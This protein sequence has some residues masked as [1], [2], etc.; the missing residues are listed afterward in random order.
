MAPGHRFDEIVK[1][2][3][4]NVADWLPR[5]AIALVAALTL[6]VVYYRSQAPGIRSAAA[7]EHAQLARNIADG[8][9][10]TTRCVRPV[11]T[12]YLRKNGKPA[13][14]I[15]SFPDLR[16]APLYPL[17]LATGLRTWRPPAKMESSILHSRLRVFAPEQRVLIPTTILFAL[18]TALLVFLMAI[19]LADLRTGLIAA[20]AYFVSDSVLADALSGTAATATTFFAT[21]ALYLSLRHAPERSAFRSVPLMAAAVACALTFLTRYAAVA[22]VPAALLILLLRVE[23]NRW[24]TAA[25]VLVLAAAV[26]APWIL[27]NIRVTGGPFGM[28]SYAVLEDSPD[29]PGDS[30]S[31]DATPQPNNVKIARAV[32]TKAVSQFGRLFDNDLRT[33]GSGLIVCFFLVSLF[34]GAGNRDPHALKWATISGI[35]CLLFV[36]AITDGNATGVLGIFLPAITVCAT[37]FFLELIGKPETIDLEWQ[38]PLAW[39]FVALAA[40]PA[41]CTIAGAHRRS[42][43]PPYYPPFVSYVCRFLDPDETICTDIPWATAW[44]GR[45]NSVLLPHSVT[46]FTKMHDAHI[47]V[48]AV[49]LTTETSDRKYADDLLDGAYRSWLP[50]L[51]RQVPPD[52]PLKHGIALPPGRHD[53]LFLTDRIRWSESGKGAG[54]GQR[55]TEKDRT[56]QKGSGVGGGPPVP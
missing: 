36:A 50:I 43:Y 15:G 6:L 46:D 18:A 21:T 22:V 7:M 5:A 4:A 20:A 48:S 32:R 24:R 34:A 3:R 19:H 41:V 9:G 47:P 55:G 10:F 44:Y 45:R 28:A 29:Y 39:S 13:Y 42:P 25:V 33:L 31:R 14:A 27:R 53:Q 30:L 38:T 11:D 56:G 2:F 52:F 49:Y 8:R 26:T 51:N 12:W 1:S 40:I 35:A 16:A 37:I 54:K 23:R 17:I